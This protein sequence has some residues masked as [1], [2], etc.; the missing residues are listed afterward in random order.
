MHSAPIKFGVGG[1]TFAVQTGPDIVHPLL[2]GKNT[3]LARSFQKFAVRKAAVDASILFVEENPIPGSAKMSVKIKRFLQKPGITFT[4]HR[5]GNIPPPPWPGLLATIE[6]TEI[7]PRELYIET[8]ANNMAIF[9]FQQRALTI[10]YSR[11]YKKQLLKSRLMGGLFAPFLPIYAA[12]LTHGAGVV[13]GLRAAVFLAPDEGGKTTAC[14]QAPP[15]SILSDDQIVMRKHGGHYFAY[16]T[17]WGVHTNSSGGHRLGAF[18]YLK[19]SDHFALAPI[20]RP[21]LMEYLWNENYGNYVPLPNRLR[22]DTF[23]L[24]WE[25]CQAVPAYEMQFTKNNVDWQAIDQALGL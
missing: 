25:I 21:Q 7:E 8:F 17:P 5:K 11:A 22:R 2:S 3:P 4:D 6:R 12:V 24:L 15:G 19:K 9:D 16:G 13:R 1:V 20:K 14:L 18:F 10:F 23:N